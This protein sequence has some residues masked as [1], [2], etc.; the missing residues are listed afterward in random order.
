MIYYHGFAPQLFNLSD[1]PH[2]LDDRA[3]D[4]SCH[5]VRDALTARVLDG[6]DPDHVRARMQVLKLE[7]MEAWASR[8]DPPDALRWDL[9][10]EM[11]YLD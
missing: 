2:E 1:D 11:D 4:P 3:A 5:A 9:R 10:P 7:L 8:V 6:W